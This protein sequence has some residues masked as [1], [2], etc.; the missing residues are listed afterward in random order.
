MANAV[1]IQKLRKEYGKKVVVKDISLEVEEDTLFALLGV[2]G[3]GKTTTIKML[4]GL[5]NPTSGDALVLG[6]SILKDQDIGESV[7][8]GNFHCPESDGS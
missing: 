1:E 6:H 3:A 4:T 8:T 2:N 5:A 7:T